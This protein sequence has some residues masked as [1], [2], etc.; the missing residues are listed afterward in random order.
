MVAESLFALGNGAMGHRGSFEEP[1]SGQTMPGNYLAGLFYLDS[2]A[3]GHHFRAAYQSKTGQCPELDWPGAGIRRRA[4]R[5]EPGGDPGVPKGAELA[6]GVPSA[7]FHGA[8]AQRQKS[9]GRGA[10]F[11]QYGGARARRPALPGPAP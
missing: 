3:S 11:L 2:P 9:S 8:V 5:P 4:V 10:A 7:Q 6:R 1:F